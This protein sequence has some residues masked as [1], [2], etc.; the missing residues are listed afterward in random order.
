[1]HSPHHHNDNKPQTTMGKEEFTSLLASE[2]WQVKPSIRKRKR[3]SQEE[4]IA[5][6]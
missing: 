4:L 6:P 1:M 3:T 2:K 5:Q